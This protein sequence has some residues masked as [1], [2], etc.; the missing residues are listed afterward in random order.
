M[1]RS[2]KDPAASLRLVPPREF[3]RARKALAE[4]LA[5][6]GRTAEARQVGRLPRPSPVVWAL[7]QAALGNARALA[8]LVES[9]DRLRR[10]QLGQGDPRA[11]T[12]GYRAVFEAVVEA[13]RAALREEGMKP[14]PA[15]DRRLRSTLLAAVTDRRLR[16]DL[17]AG[18]LAA[19]YA[20][21]GFSVLSHGPI[22]AEFLRGRAARPSATP[23]RASRPA[24]PDQDVAAP[25]RAPRPPAADRLARKQA[26][27]A[28]RRVARE[29]ARVAQRAA[30][31]AA[32]ALTSLDRAARRKERAAQAAETRV[33]AQRIA[34]REREARSAA[35]RTAADEARAAHG[36]AVAAARRAE[37]Q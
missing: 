31:E 10:A 9:V 1:A 23:R 5:R 4:R 30:R 7:N 20:E 12:A 36:R 6:S 27:T 24:P 14:S 25:G 16:A 18:R 37:T 26:E 33:A 19:E 28:A 8:T 34:L 2:S 17:S 13:A 29:N 11:A 15:V 21:P 35:L 32:R 22:P 3:T